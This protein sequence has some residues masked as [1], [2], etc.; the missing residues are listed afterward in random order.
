MDDINGIFERDAQRGKEIRRA[1][2]VKMGFFRGI[3]LLFRFV[4][5]APDSHVISEVPLVFK[6]QYSAIRGNDDPT[7]EVIEGTTK[8][9]IALSSALYWAKA[10]HLRVMVKI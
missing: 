5:V 1:A 9:M 8:K 6:P 2:R 7:A 10:C 4:T 3:L